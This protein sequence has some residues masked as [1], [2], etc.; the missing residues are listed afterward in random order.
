VI[1]NSPNGIVN[2]AI[3]PQS[4]NNATGI[5]SNLCAN[6]F[7][8]TV[9]D[10]AG[11]TA[12]SVVGVSQP[13]ALTT[14]V[15]TIT[16]V[17]C[18]GANNGTI[19]YTATG[20]TGLIIYSINPPAAG[21]GGNYFNLAP[22]IY[23]VTA[24]D[25]NNCTT[26]QVFTISE[27]SALFI[28]SATATST[29]CTGQSNGT[30]TLNISG[31]T[32]LYTATGNPS[33]NAGPSNSPLVMTGLG[34][35]NYIV[36]VTDAN[37]CNTNTNVV[38]GGSIPIVFNSVTPNAP[39]C[40]GI[41]NGSISVITSGGSGQI[42][43]T[44]SPSGPQQ[45][46]T[47]VFVN[48]CGNVT[49][50]ITATDANAC[51]VTTS[52]SLADPLA[53]SVAT[54]QT[55]PACFGNNNGSVT[56]VASGGSGAGYTFSISP[57]ANQP[58]NGVFNQMLAGTY[59]ITA[60][61]GLG[62]TTTISVTLDNPSQ[63]IW[64]NTSF[65]NILCNGNN[66]GVIAVNA[67]GGAGNFIYSINPAVQAS[68]PNGVFTN[69]SAQCYTITASDANQCTISTVI[70]ITEPP[71]L[72]LSAPIVV[73]VLC[74]GD[75]TGA[76]NISA[77]G[78][79]PGQGY[80][81]NI[82]PNLGVQL[83]PGS[84]TNL[85][86]GNY[87][88]SATD[89]NGCVISSNPIQITQ[90]PA[91]SITSLN[92]QDVA[93]FGEATGTITLTAQGGTGALSYEIKPSAQQPSPGFFINLTAGQYTVSVVDI[94]GCRVSSVVVI[95]Q[96]PEIVLN[97]VIYT[98][99][100]CFGDKNGR[101]QIFVSGGV[102]PLQFSL[103]NGPFQTSNIFSDLYAGYYLLSI[104]DALGCAKELVLHLTQP[105]PVG[106]ELDLTG[107]N[108]ADSKDGKI[109]ATGT[110]GRGGYVY[111]ITPGLNINKSGVFNG[112]AVGNYTLRVVD[113]TGCEY[114]T[115]FTINP[116]QFP[117]FN[118][119]TKQ[120]LACNGKGNEGFATA[121][122]SGGTPPY[123][124]MWNTNPVQTTPTAS[125]LYFGL[126][127]VE[128]VDANGCK[129]IDSVYIEE[130]PCCDVAFIP[131]AFTPNGDGNNDEFRVL[132]TAGIELQQLEIYDRWGN[133]VWSTTDF[134][135]G[136]DGYRDGQVADVDTYF[137]I[138]RYRCTRDGRNYIKKGDVSLIR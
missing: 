115:P 123:T 59:I 125:T 24:T 116:P 111:Y 99:P 17:T 51:T 136:W 50:T 97:N 124:Y 19:T 15:S 76:I 84:F 78:G 86:A 137:Y 3:I 56:A 41:C 91:I 107:A 57:N 18:N 92:S 66:N 49:Y 118:T 129:I 132:T 64:N 38:V 88:V 27:P 5:F 63:I 48:L 81:Y 100:I 30:I 52:V 126:Y 53:V 10:G 16:N 96:N 113:T 35:N 14:N 1:A 8:V 25:I 12:V 34:P 37:G 75:Q 21:S 11:C 127:K 60:A 22:N 72:T 47:G 58:S 117:L 105:E 9:T 28:N 101:I 73:N 87:I 104:R 29:L 114:Q 70:C 106:A 61:D 93:C 67:G 44:I 31:G 77:S 122:V 89:A 130:G 109:I 23:T 128:I 95:N 135:R 108:C 138:F 39:T 71:A 13:N 20:G 102:A 74:F 80:I 103:N 42:N 131:N 90:P 82:N 85:P 26:Q 46:T 94:N 36:T 121:N 7:N 79:T 55:N 112:L 134:R 120:D 54:Q 68:N 133:R 65:S 4:Q 110:G 6:V 40:N 83:S 2:Y 98:E 32:G 33:G 43:Y 69:L 62:C 119:M 45:N